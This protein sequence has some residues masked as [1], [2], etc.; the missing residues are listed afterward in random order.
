MTAWAATLLLAS[1]AGAPSGA[2]ATVDYDLSARLDPVTHTVEGRGTLRWTHH[3]LAPVRSLPWHLYLNA[4]KNDRTT[5]M[6]E[7]DLGSLRG[8]EF[9]REHWGHID[10]KSMQVHLPDGGRADLLIRAKFIQ[11]D[12]GNV[13]D[14]TVLETPLPF[15]VAPGETI[16]VDFE[17]VSQLPK[18]FARSG[19]SGSF[20]MVAQWFPKIGVL[21]ETVT[22]TVGE[23]RWNCHQYHATSEY[24]A[25]YGRFSVAIDVPDGYVVGASG[26]RV[27]T[28]RADGRVVHTHVVEDVHDFAW[29]ADS[30]F[31]VIERRFDASAIDPADV[32]RV[33]K[34]LG[35]A[36]DELALT[37]VDVRL[38]IQPEHRQYAERYF[39][40]TFAALKWFGLWYGAYPYPV[41]TVVDGPRGASGAMGMEYPTLITGGVSWPSP[42]GSGRPEN[43]TI[44][45]F[46]HQ[47]WYGLVGSNEFEEAW[48]DEGLNTYSTGK[49]VDAAF[50]PFV[51]VPNIGGLP[52]TPWFSSVTTS[53]M[54]V[55]RIGTM[56]GGDR[57]A[58]VRR[59]WT[60]ESDGSYGM[61]NY[62]R[63]ALTLRQ[64]ENV[65]GEANLIR[66]MRRY[67][68][69]YRFRHPTTADFVAVLEEV[70]G[71]SL[72]HFT[73]RALFT[74]DYVDYAITQ[75]S[76]K[77]KKVAA[78][79][80]D[81]DGERR[82]VDKD[83]VKDEE[84]DVYVTK[85]LARRETSVDFPVTIE[86]AFEDGTT[87]RL[88]WDGA[89]RWKRFE[90]ETKSRAV[91][92]QL[93]PD[94]EQLLDLRRTNDSR[95]RKKSHLAAASWGTSALYVVQIMLQVLGGLL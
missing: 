29:T 30:R 58:L 1:I 55:A 59:S 39:A 78:G 47:Y 14:Q 31:E 9:D 72:D 52:L 20:H 71:A 90:L 74:P 48:L 40:A 44:H 42:D 63:S 69:R 13:D 19:F 6:R 62:P 51:R 32:E 81:E 76:S 66:A 93:H 86:V 54:D 28:R 4:F 67:Q 33:A 85:I 53:P 34:K 15:D 60:Y 24:F 2:P 95:R 75:F 16:A 10:V 94:G 7:S 41:L 21:Q 22:G 73:R 3:G 35:L 79:V 25:D 38:L 12:D 70:H 27:D 91:S 36:P 26:R 92:A 46:G 80:F 65:M 43:V 88:E 77:K 64:L 23:P 5:F 37:D 83:D 49:V 11:P 8:D 56:L 45:E 18:V 61:N 87:Q 50:G 68:E 84:E 82:T 17:F 57:D 89:Y